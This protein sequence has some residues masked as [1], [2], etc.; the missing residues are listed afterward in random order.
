ME[1]Q[2]LY[3]WKRT[4]VRRD[5]NLAAHT[6]AK[7]AAQYAIEKRWRDDPPECVNDLLSLER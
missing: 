1:L 2:G 4:H 3:Q 6:L 5:R 7:Y